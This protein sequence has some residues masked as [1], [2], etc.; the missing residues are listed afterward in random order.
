MA[1]KQVFEDHAIN[2]AKAVSHGNFFESKCV[3]FDTVCEI[4]APTVVL[5]KTPIKRYVKAKKCDPIVSS[6]GLGVYKHIRF[7]KEGLVSN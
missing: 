4:R 5:I 7:G 6:V 3:L 1:F 2:K